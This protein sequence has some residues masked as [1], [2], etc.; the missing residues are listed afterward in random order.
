[1]HFRSTYL[2]DYAPSAG[3]PP[4]AV[5]SRVAVVSW[6]ATSIPSG[7]GLWW[8]VPMWAVMAAIAIAALVIRH[9]R[10]WRRDA[11]V[12]TLCMSGCAIAA[13]IPPAYFEGIA[14]TRHLIGSNL[15]SALAVLASVVLVASLVHQ[16]A[17]R[18]WRFRRRRARL[19]ST[20]GL[21][22]SEVVLVTVRVTDGPSGD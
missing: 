20:P 4:G 13:F 12:V 8:L 14:E 21:A 18:W 10:P 1:M 19:P 17:A 22:A 7:L 2:G 11:A 16:A 15:A 3:H 9:G 6:L 5:E